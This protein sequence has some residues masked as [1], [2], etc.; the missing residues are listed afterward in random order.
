M[1]GEDF[2]Q[3]MS[4][5]G[6]MPFAGDEGRPAPWN[7]S[8]N[9]PAHCNRSVTICFTMPEIDRNTDFF[10]IETL[11]NEALNPPHIIARPTKNMS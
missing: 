3:V 2:S 4:S 6:K 11:W 10:Q 8:G 1:G 9:L 7:G 5:H